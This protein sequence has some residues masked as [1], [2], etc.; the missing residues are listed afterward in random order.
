[1]VQYNGFAIIMYLDKAYFNGN[2]LR[3]HTNKMQPNLD[4]K[5][6]VRQWYNKV[7]NY[8]DKIVC[9][10]LMLSTIFYNF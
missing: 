4:Y 5:K 8:T 6:Y 3:T 10:N 1:M 9:N 7:I 2:N